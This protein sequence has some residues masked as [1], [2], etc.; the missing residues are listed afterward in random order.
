MTI[1]EAIT[2]F[3][4]EKGGASPTREDFATQEGVKAL[5]DRVRSAGVDLRYDAAEPIGKTIAGLFEAVA[6]EHLLQPTI[7][8]EFPTAVFPLS[9]QI[10]D[11]RDGTEPFEM[12][13]GKR[14][15]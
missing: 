7:I 2:K 5:V 6:E 13:P 4:P 12:L 15:F 9:K 10:P 11:D 8:Y 3:W 1:R 14:D